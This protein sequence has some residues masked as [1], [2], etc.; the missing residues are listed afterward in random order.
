MCVFVCFDKTKIYMIQS[1]IITIL[2]YSLS[3]TQPPNGITLN[4]HL[5]QNS[6]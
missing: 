4:S 1:M 5:T 6:C 2:L 3:S